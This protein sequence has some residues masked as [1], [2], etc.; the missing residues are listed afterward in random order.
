MNCTLSN[1][2]I[3]SKIYFSICDLL[4]G[5]LLETIWKKYQFQSYEGYVYHFQAIT[6]NIPNKKIFKLFKY[7]NIN[8]L[9]LSQQQ[10]LKQ[11]QVKL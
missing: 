4:E 11:I 10:I 3:A 2:I 7:E 5:L 6:G 1:Y 9:T 8:A